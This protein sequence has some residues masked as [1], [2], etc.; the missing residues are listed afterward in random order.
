MPKLLHVLESYNTTIDIYKIRMFALLGRIYKK[1][2][3]RM[4]FKLLADTKK[5]YLELVPMPFEDLPLNAKLVNI[6][7]YSAFLDEHRGSLGQAKAWA[8]KCLTLFENSLLFFEK[9]FRV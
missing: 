1:T 7:A 8:K 4:L 6:P 9:D 3:I 5:N 2:F